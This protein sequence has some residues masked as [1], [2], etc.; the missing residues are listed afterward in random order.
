MGTQRT[1]PDRP[2][3]RLPE[4]GPWPDAGQSLEQGKVGLP[5]VLRGGDTKFAKV[6]G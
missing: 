5:R 4:Q 1:R 2:P 6:K 3:A